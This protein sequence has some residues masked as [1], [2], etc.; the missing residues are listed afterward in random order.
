MDAFT[1]HTEERHRQ[2]KEKV[3]DE[4]Q[5][6]LESRKQGETLNE[7]NQILDNENNVVVDID[8]DYPDW[9][10]DWEH[11]NDDLQVIA[12]ILYDH[13]AKSAIMEK[14]KSLEKQPGENKEA[15]TSAISKF[16]KGIIDLTEFNQMLTVFE[17]QRH[18][19]GGKR[20]RKRRHTHKRRVSR[21][22]DRRRT[23]SRARHN[24]RRTR[25]KTRRSRAHRSKKRRSK[26][27]RSKA[28]H[29]RRRTRS[30]TRRSAAHRSKTHR[31]KR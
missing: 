4:V 28:R 29:S 16:E 26:A 7:R 3:R 31:R 25:S 24:R 1:K 14:A 6:F 21:T 15:I 2:K 19:G 5:T 12:R 18:I 11:N 10:K 13:Y 20:L 30:K 22:V 8:K 9:W 17:R 27:R 23:R